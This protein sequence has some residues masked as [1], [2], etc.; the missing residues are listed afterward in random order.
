MEKTGK[1]IAASFA[2]VILMAGC[3]SSVGV[4]G[5]VVD[6]DRDV[7]SKTTKDKD[8]K[9]KTEVK[10]TY[11]LTTATET[12]KETEFKVSAVVY[13]RCQLNESYP[14]CAG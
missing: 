3:S 4:A 7:K 8:G 14:K 12:G 1:V 11:E 6:R 5:K 10:V 13:N 9:K 2:A